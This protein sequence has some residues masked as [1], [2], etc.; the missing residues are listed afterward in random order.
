MLQ[1]LKYFD[2]F[3]VA[4]PLV[5]NDLMIGSQIMLFPETGNEIDSHAV[6][7]YFED[8]KIG[9]IPADQNECIASP[10]CFRQDTKSSLQLSSSFPHMNIRRNRLEL[11]YIFVTEMKIRKK[12]QPF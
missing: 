12:K 1:E 8:Q 2:S 4:G 10:K 6:A 7:L 11:F 5:F 3:H 9:Y